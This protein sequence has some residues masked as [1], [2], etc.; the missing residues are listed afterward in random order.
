MVGL[1]LTEL[2]DECVVVGVAD[3]RV[4]ERVVALVVVRDLRPELIDP[5]G[6]GHRFVG[7]R[8]HRRRG[9]DVTQPQ[10]IPKFGA[11]SALSATRAPS[12]GVVWF[13]QAPSA[14]R[15]AADWSWTRLPT[16]AVS[17]AIRRATDTECIA[18]PHCG[19][20]ML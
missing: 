2:S 13:F 4:V 14:K 19:V 15:V 7:V 5:Q 11:S 17:R 9:Y 12:L 18:R 16:S 6:R 20:T 8:G 1:E 10:T 3:L